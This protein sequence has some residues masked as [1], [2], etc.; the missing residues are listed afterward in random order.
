MNCI[1]CKTS[2]LKRTGWDNVYDRLS[3]KC[4]KTKITDW[5]YYLVFWPM[6]KNKPPENYRFMRDPELVKVIPIIKGEK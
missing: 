1:E 5:I 6:I 3:C 2:L 4:G